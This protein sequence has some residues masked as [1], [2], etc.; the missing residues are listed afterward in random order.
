MEWWNAALQVAA[1]LL[2][3]ASFWLWGWIHD[4]ASERRWWHEWY[5]G[6]SPPE[7]RGDTEG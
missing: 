7:D 5:W 2:L 4:R 3:A 1:T 6:T